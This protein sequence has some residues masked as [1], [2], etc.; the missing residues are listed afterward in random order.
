[1][2]DLE[3]KLVR[4]TRE[5]VWYEPRIIQD[6]TRRLFADVGEQRAIEAVGT[7]ALCNSLSRLSLVRQ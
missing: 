5:T 4:W 1:M 7:A 6:S 2:T 3:T